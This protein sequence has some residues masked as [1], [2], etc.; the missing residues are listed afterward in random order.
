M[1]FGEFCVEFEL[2]VGG[3]VIRQHLVNMEEIGL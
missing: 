3:E 2:S 1:E